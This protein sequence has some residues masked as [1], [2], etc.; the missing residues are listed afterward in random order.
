[1]NKTF[2]GDDVSPSLRFF[3]RNHFQQ[4]LEDPDF[5]VVFL[6][7]IQFNPRFYQSR[8]YKIQFKYVSGLEGLVRKIV[9]GDRRLSDATIRIFRNMFLGAFTHMTLRWFV[10]GG[11]VA[12]DQMGEIDTVTDLLSN[13]LSVGS[14][15]DTKTKET[16]L[17]G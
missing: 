8:A 15:A 9:D 12:Y 5:L 11:G 6:T 7:L 17:M 2:A 10:V 4:Y 14:P 1:M 16:R 13:I 3:M